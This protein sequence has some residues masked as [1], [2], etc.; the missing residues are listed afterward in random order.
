VQTAYGNHLYDH[1]FQHHRVYCDIAIK[2]AD[3]QFTYRQNNCMHIDNRR[4]GSGIYQSGQGCDN[5]L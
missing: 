3:H 4:L 1:R 5:F 2:C